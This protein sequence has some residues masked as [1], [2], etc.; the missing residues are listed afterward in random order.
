MMKQQII[1]CIDGSN[2]T[3]AVCQWAAWAATQLQAP[4]KLLHVLT[5]PATVATAD[6]SG[7]IGLGSQEALLAQLVELDQQRNKLAQEQ[8][9]HLL[10]A[11]RQIVQAHQVTGHELELKSC[12]R[13]GELPE[14]L[15]E[16]ET[17]TRLVIMGRQ[18]EQHAGLHSQVGSELE[19]VVR[20]LHTPILMALPEFKVPTRVMFAYDGSSTGRSALNRLTISP[21]LQGLHCDLVMVGGE[22]QQ[23]DEAKVL[24]QAAGVQV[25]PY[26][27]T[28]DVET[29]LLRHIAAEQID[30][31][32][33]G[34]YGHSRLRQFLLGSH[35]SR[36]LSQSPVPLLLLR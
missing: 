12:Q 15:Q 6:W 27:L 36:M 28:G 14:A 32:I 2:S 21:L 18:G 20:M 23:L 17:A 3:P 5:K 30:L 29:A 9:N 7:S 13:H 26:T 25:T 1:A 34:A 8:G 10:Q 22:P 31:V 33:M 4:L 11:A 35:T 24:L 16:L 19:S